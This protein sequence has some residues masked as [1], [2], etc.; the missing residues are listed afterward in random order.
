MNIENVDKFGHCVICHNNLIIKRIIDGKEQEVFMPIHGQ[1]TFLLKN[2]SQMEVCMCK[3][4]Q[5]A[6][7]LDDPI[8]HEAIMQSVHKGWKLETNMLIEKG[9][10]SQE[11]GEKYLSHMKNY[12]IDSHIQNLSTSWVQNRIKEL[13]H[14]HYSH[15]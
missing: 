9:E 3:P 2:G 1:T 13:T 4:C 10:W 7:Q 6:T 12:K 15:T 5:Q 8:V 11:H 14:E